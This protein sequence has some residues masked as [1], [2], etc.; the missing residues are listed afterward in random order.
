MAKAKS[1]E[2]K[3]EKRRLNWRDIAT[4]IGTVTVLS[5]L[6]MS[7]VAWVHAESTIPKILQKT[8]E[9]V[10]K[11]IDRHT[12]HPHPVSV[13]RREFEILTTDLKE[14]IGKVESAVKEFKA[15]NKER[16]DRIEEKIDRT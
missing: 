1:G 11:A 2:P 7:I 14:D 3:E 12:K 8:A 4:I 15:E 13:P 5:G 10:E 6:V 16:L 9:Q